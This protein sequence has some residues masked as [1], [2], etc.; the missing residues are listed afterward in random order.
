[1]HAKYVD[2]ARQA[3]CYREP[4]TDSLRPARGIVVAV[5]GSVVFWLIVAAA[6]L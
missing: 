2:L 6:V 3:D 4:A 1:M 5:I